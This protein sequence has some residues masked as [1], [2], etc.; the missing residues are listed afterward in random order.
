MYDPAA[1]DRWH[2][3]LAA[4]AVLLASICYAAAQCMRLT[5]EQAVVPEA[6]L[7]EAV[8]PEKKRA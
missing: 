5:L 3:V 1:F 4:R 8:V 6:V 2:E 7:P